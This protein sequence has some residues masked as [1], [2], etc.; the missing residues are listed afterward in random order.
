MKMIHWRI[1]PSVVTDDLS[2]SVLR[3]EDLEH[4]LHVVAGAVVV[5]ILSSSVWL[6]DEVIILT[7]VKLKSVGQW[8]EGAEGQSEDSDE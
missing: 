5:I 1:S 6:G 2:D 7:W 3:V 4:D 8:G